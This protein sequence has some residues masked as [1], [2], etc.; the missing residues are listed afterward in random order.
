LVIDTTKKFVPK[1]GVK[2]RKFKD[3]SVDEL[4]GFLLDFMQTMDAFPIHKIRDSDL[5]D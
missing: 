5:T 3:M 2:A 4:D 1:Q